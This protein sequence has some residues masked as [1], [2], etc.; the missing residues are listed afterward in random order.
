MTRGTLTTEN[1]RLIQFGNKGIGGQ[2]LDSAVEVTE[3]KASS[4][5]GTARNLQLFNSAILTSISFQLAKQFIKLR[6][7]EEHQNHLSERFC[8]SVHEHRR[9]Q[10]SQ[11]SR[12]STSRSQQRMMMTLRRDWRAATR[13]KTARFVSRAQLIQI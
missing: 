13:T 5:C 9:E 1:F 4:S 7:N 6:E 2:V 8:V 12:R 10:R 11:F 3:T